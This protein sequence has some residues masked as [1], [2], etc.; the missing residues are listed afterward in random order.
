[1]SSPSKGQDATEPDLLGAC[2]EKLHTK[3]KGD[4]TRQKNLIVYFVLGLGRDGYHP[5]KKPRSEGQKDDGCSKGQK[6]IL[7]DH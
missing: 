3:K 6:K 4:L 2:W 7:I 1:M 5:Q